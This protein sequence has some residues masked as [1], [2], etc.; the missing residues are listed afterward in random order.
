M[1][2]RA[3][4]TTVLLVVTEPG[5]RN[6]AEEILLAE[7]AAVDA[8]C[9]RFRADSEISR[10]HRNPGSAVAVGPVLAQALTVA[11]R[12]G[13]LTNG[14]VDPTV[15]RA[16]CALGYDRDLAAIAP[17]TAEP[18]GPARPAP[19]WWRV[20][21]DPQRRE[22]VLPRGIALDLGATAKALAVDRVAGRV[23][24]ELGCGV[25]VSIGG[26]VRAAGEAP[27]GGW[28]VGVG[29]DHER[30]LTDPDETV[31]ITGGGLATS[32]TAR[33]AWRRAGRLVHHIVDPR[34]GD[35]PDGR[36]RTVTVAAASCVD[37]NTASTAAVVM[38]DHAPAW[39][40]A[41]RLPARLVADDGTVTDA[42]SA[43]RSTSAVTDAASAGRSTSAVTTTAGW[44]G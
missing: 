14:L 20:N 44:G 13:E 24:D 12:A 29:D 39:L 18:A 36:W 1:A 32:G 33:R 35:V 27:A 4:G 42:A 6:R 10:L 41:C 23:V 16:V 38:G 34:T 2:L 22:V 5:A 28:L 40:E 17:D 26:D 15:G 19:G 30:A 21:W 8:A 11:L 9:S 7:L 37:A 31:E 25:L 3:W 43:G